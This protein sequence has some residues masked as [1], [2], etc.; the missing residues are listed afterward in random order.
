[1]NYEEID[2]ITNESWIQ[3]LL[4]MQTS[5][6]LALE[7]LEDSE[8]QNY[9][10]GI[11]DS[12]KT[13]GYCY[14]RFSDFSLSLSHSLRALD[15]YQ[16]I[17]DKNGEANTL[18]NIGAVYMFQNDHQKRLEVNRQ[19][20]Q[21]RLEIGDLEGVAS[22]EGNIGETYLEM[23]DYENALKCFTNVLEHPKVSP[24]GIA[25][26]YHNIGRINLAN[27]KYDEALINYEKGLGI[28][29]SVNYDVL[30]TDSHLNITELFILQNKFDDALKSAESSLE[31]ARKIGA[32]EGEKK[33]L[34]Y[35]SKIYESKGQFEAS[36]KYHKD[37]HTIDMEISRD[38]EIERLKTTQ[39]KV[40][41]DK[42]EDQRNELID[43]IKYAER[44]QNAVLMRNEKQKLVLNHF[45]CFQPKDIVS[46]D[47]YWFHQKGNYF[48]LC[49]ADCTGHGVPGAFLT[50]LGTAF[51]NEIIALRENE[52]PSS[53]L[54]DLRFRIIQTLSHSA[55]G[56]QDG[57][58]ISM[59][60][61]NT[62]TKVAEW[63]G[64]YNPIIIVRANDS[65][66][67]ETS[68]KY[69]TLKNDTHA[70]YEIK[71][72]KQPVGLMSKMLPFKNHK[73]QLEKGDAIYL[74]S[75]GFA[76]QFGGELNKKFKS[77][78]LKKAFLDFQ[79]LS[80]AEQGENLITIFNDWKGNREQVDD[81]CIIG[82]KI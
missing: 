64:A 53:I 37:Y 32:K 35:L 48:Y 74:Y 63:S 62:E 47:F 38:T 18:N 80:M 28:S 59:I 57:M 52:T 15:L 58:D 49:V 4:D 54:D 29:Q 22:S 21:I 69:E 61:L 23:G 8:K 13:L 31:V 42:I 10:K 19:C 11:A 43:S 9:K 3:R 45:V 81:V 39:L 2:R 14:W 5:Y 76:D 12:C 25:W 68:S 51:L 27:L 34:Y 50:M 40:A 79:G 26:A 17:G 33:A 16:K 1:M 36:L 24:Q 78:N 66:S 77:N 72:D 56:G 73:I 7:A 67:L 20:K 44:I 41:Y 30:V 60:R 46:G 82:F 65:S 71:G 70:L 55:N 6:S 75:D